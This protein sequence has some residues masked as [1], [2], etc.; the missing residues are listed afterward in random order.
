MSK[1]VNKIEPKAQK[2]RDILEDTPHTAE[3]EPMETKIILIKAPTLV[4]MISK[5]LDVSNGKNASTFRKVTLNRFLYL[6]SSPYHF[7]FTCT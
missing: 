4:S 6:L 3:E 1:Q 5:P 2:K 7:V